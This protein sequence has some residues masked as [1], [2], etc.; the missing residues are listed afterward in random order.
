LR[1]DLHG[2]AAR[3]AEHDGHVVLAGAHL[4]DLRR[5]VDDLIDRHQREVEGHELDD[6][7]EPHHRGAD[8]DPGE[9]HLGDWRVDHAAL[10]EPLEQALG[11][12]VRAVVVADL[13]A[14]DEHVGIALHLLAHRLVERLA[15]AD[16]RHVH[17]LTTYGKYS[18]AGGESSAN[19]TAS[20]ISARTSAS[21]SSSLA[22]C[23]PRSTS[24]WRQRLS[25]SRRRH[26]STSSLVRYRPGS[27]IEWPPNR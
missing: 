16:D 10:A 14:H 2:R 11:H 3:A 6:R 21:S 17:S 13:L 8:P 26:S 25:G 15:V 23:I 19:L 5:V 27:L 22:S 1:A 12:L 18:S 20:S 7:P 4:V 9:P 24:R